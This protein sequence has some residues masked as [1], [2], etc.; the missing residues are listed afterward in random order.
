[1]L[2]NKK[3]IYTLNIENKVE[4]SK[5]LTFLQAIKEGKM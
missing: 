5:P 4:S 1:M 3:L 2:I